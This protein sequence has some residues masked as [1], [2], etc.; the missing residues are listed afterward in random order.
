[1]EGSTYNSAKHI[2]GVKMDAGKG[3]AKKPFNIRD[4][5]DSSD[6]EGEG[7]PESPTPGQSWHDLTYTGWV[8]SKRPTEHPVTPREEALQ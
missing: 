5:L 7:A 6:S 4:I 2:N 3:E 1:M 8:S